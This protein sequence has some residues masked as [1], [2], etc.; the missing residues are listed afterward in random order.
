MLATC[1]TQGAPY[2]L[3]PFDLVP[4]DVDGFLD[5]LQEFHTDRQSLCRCHRASEAGSRVAAALAHGT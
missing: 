1:R 4:T 2:V 5:E 3:P